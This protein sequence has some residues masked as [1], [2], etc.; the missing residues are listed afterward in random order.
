MHN[1]H[2]HSGIDNADPIELPAAIG[3]CER[4]VRHQ[5]TK[6]TLLKPSL[7]G[8]RFHERLP[9]GEVPDCGLD[10]S[11]A[12][13]RRIDDDTLVKHGLHVFDETLANRK[14]L[15]MLSGRNA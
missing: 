10:D 15:D 9:Y 13:K 7:D 1:E 4:D 12:T 14:G 3:V 6:V 8:L 2:A 5:L 11:T